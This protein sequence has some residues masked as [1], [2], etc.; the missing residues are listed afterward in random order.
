MI[1]REAVVGW[2]VWDETGVCAQE[3]RNRPVKGTELNNAS[4]F[5]K[6]RLSMRSFTFWYPLC[7][8]DP[9]AELI[10]DFTMQPY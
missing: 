4:R 3:A 5:R 8:A 7:D 9:L 6:L 10:L 1:L 2:G